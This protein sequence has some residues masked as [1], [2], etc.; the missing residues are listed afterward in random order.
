MTYNA[1]A[2]AAAAASSTNYWANHAHKLA[3]YLAS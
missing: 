3:I 2:A 1:A